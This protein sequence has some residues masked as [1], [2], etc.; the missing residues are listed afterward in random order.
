MLRNILVVAALC[1]PL[2]ACQT[3][4]GGSFDKYEA[5][6]IKENLVK[7]KTTKADVRRI[8]GEPESMN[9]DSYGES[10]WYYS[11][12]NYDVTG[13]VQSTLGSIS[14]YLN[15]VPMDKQSRSLSVHFN[16]AG[17]LQHYTVGAARD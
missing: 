7:G 6:F 2:T 11:D 14:G 4:Q 16:P 1:L 13:L 8:Y 15:N 12:N 9:D 3:L 5:S 10:S 17:V